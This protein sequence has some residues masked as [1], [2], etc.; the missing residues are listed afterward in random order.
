MAYK[1]E[2]STSMRQG[3]FLWMPEGT[4]SEYLVSLHRKIEEGYFFSEKI[5]SCIVEE[6]A[7][8]YSDSINDE[9]E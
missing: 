3:R 6:L 1:P 7:P 2:R 8:A 9:S 4:R 5:L